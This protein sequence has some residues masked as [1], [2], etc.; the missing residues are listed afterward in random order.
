M[1]D[2]IE[3]FIK[4]Q[5]EGEDVLTFIGIGGMYT[6]PDNVIQYPMAFVD[7]ME[8]GDDEMR[9]QW[10]EACEKM[11][12]VDEFSKGIELTR[13]SPESVRVASRRRQVIM[14]FGAGE[15]NT[16][17][18]NTFFVELHGDED[19]IDEF[20]RMSKER[21]TWV[22]H[23]RT[24]HRSYVY[25]VATSSGNVLSKIRKDKPDDFGEMKRK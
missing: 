15:V 20:Y 7:Y 22:L 1:G 5:I 17:D 4:R 3:D 14:A 9:K 16:L 2:D 19:A 25:I 24:I 13:L 12:E 8:S 6:S 10:S 11:W 18:T 21:D 23:L